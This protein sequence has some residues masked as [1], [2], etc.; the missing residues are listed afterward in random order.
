EGQEEVGLSSRD[1]RIPQERRTHRGDAEGTRRS[2]EE[3]AEG[4]G[5]PGLR[6]SESRRT[7][8]PVLFL[9]EAPRPPRLR[10]ALGLRASARSGARPSERAHPSRGSSL[11]RA[12]AASA[13]GCGAQE[14]RGTRL[15]HATLEDR[16]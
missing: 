12:A 4:L 2:A 5:P 10:G 6:V 15:V 13:R 16:S 14:E 9:R 11:L 1:A 8:G 3:E 7:R